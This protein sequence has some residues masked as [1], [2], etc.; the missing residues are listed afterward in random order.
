MDRTY[1]L[2]RIYTSENSAKHRNT[3]LSEMYPDV[4]GTK[5]AVEKALNRRI[6]DAKAKGFTVEEIS[7]EDV[8]KGHYF[9]RV[10]KMQQPLG[11]PAIYGIYQTVSSFN[12]GEMSYREIRQRKVDS[13]NEIIFLFII[14]M[15]K[16]LRG[17]AI[18]KSID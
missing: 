18:S 11:G 5:E 14:L 10:I 7:S 2:H 17:D 3:Q 1:I 9:D 4:A 16:P 12:T 13:F 8:H 6:E 15:T